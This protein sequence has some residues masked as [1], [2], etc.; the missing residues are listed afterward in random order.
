MENDNIIYAN[1][2]AGRFSKAAKTYGANASIQ[3]LTADILQRE[4]AGRNA[5]LIMEAGCGSGNFTEIISEM[6]PDAEITAV[7]FSEEMIRL[8]LN[9]NKHRNVKYIC[10]NAEYPP[11][12]YQPDMILS[13]ACLHWFFDLPAAINRYCRSLPEGGLL[14]FSSFGPQTYIELNG[15]IAEKQGLES[16]GAMSFPSKEEIEGILNLYF[17]DILVTEYIMKEEYGSLMQ[18]LKKIK[19]TGVNMSSLG[20]PVSLTRTNIFELEKKYIDKYGRI[21]ATYQIFCCRAVK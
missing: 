4:I 12:D 10:A 20:K 5:K 11:P 17:R 15:L 21:T 2:I 8:A 18:L 6:F 19:A 7:D 16:F 14:A 3:K 9:N 13:N 1:P